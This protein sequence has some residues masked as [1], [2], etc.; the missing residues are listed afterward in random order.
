MRHPWLIP[1]FFTKR[2]TLAALKGAALVSFF[3][4]THFGCAELPAMA[5]TGVH[6]PASPINA[7]DYDLPCAVAWDLAF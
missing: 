7:R 4:K 6:R 3:V 2:I 1:R 5:V